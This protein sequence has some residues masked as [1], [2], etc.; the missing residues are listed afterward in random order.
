MGTVRADSLLKWFG[1]MEGG[2]M[3]RKLEG[4]VKL[5]NYFPLKVEDLYLKACL[6]SGRNVLVKRVRLKI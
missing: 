3:D 4:R 6:T 2:Q 5:E 1:K